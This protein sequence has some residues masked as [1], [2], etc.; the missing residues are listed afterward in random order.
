[1]TSKGFT[2]IELL[3]VMAVLALF[4]ALVPP[5]LFKGLSPAQLK[6]AAREVAGGLRQARSD[7]IL[8][9]RDVGFTIDVE[10]RRYTI[11]GDAPAR[12]LPGELDISLYTAQSELADE[13]TGTIRFFSDGSSTGGRVTLAHDE[14]K[15]H[16]SVD[17]LTG[18][19]AITE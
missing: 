16:V 10:G 1:M 5:I 13:A 15:Y 9:N 19:I 12:H 6:S 8:R 2:L 14:R 4:L 18:Q 7:A 17:W 11:G 3:V